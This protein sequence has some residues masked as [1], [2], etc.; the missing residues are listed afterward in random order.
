[1]AA[2]TSAPAVTAAPAPAPAQPTAGAASGTVAPQATPKPKDAPKGSLAYGSACV[3]VAPS[4]V[5]MGAAG[6]QGLVRQ[7]SVSFQVTVT[8][9]ALLVSPSLAPLSRAV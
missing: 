1:M 8:A 7:A 5:R 2:L 9:R 4:P 6:S 3:L